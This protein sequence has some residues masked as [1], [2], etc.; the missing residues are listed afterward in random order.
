MLA[1]S[2]GTTVPTTLARTFLSGGGSKPGFRRAWNLSH[3]VRTNANNYL[4]FGRGTRTDS[5]LG[6]LSWPT[7]KGISTFRF[8]GTQT[9]CVSESH[10][11]ISTSPTS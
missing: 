7:V 4:A 2:K 8:T 1:S 3:G 6:A 5:F 9:E 10:T 11:T